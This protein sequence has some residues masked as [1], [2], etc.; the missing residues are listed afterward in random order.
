MSP[1]L[2]WSFAHA[3]KE[4]RDLSTHGGDEDWVAVLP[5]GT[6]VPEW[7]QPGTEFGICDV[8]KY[9]HPRRPGWRVFIGAH[10]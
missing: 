4:L 9:E 5:P 10:A 2:V 7:M 1:I 3:P 6:H 8:W